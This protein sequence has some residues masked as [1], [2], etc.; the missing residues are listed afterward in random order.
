MANSAVVWSG[1]KQFL[2]LSANATSVKE[3]TLLK[4]L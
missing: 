2:F 3:L 1:A 4:V